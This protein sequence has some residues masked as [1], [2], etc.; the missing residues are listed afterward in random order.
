M[1]LAPRSPRSPCKRTKMHLLKSDLL[2][3]IT[4]KLIRH[5]LI[6]PAVFSPHP[7][8]TRH[9]GPELARAGP[10]ACPAAIH[11]SRRLPRNLPSAPTPSL[12]YYTPPPARPPPCPHA[13][14]SST[15][16]VFTA[17]R[18]VRRMGCPAPMVVSNVTPSLEEHVTRLSSY[19][20]TRA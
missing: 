14:R 4:I 8:D 5:V 1:C 18:L 13:L 15:R 2:K 12:Q 7:C 10:D 11:L 17:D 19:T 9:V 16:A 6:S 3:T 20:I